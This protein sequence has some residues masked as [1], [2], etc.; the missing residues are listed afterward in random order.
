MGNIN[1]TQILIKAGANIHTRDNISERTPLLAAANMNQE[2]YEIIKLLLEADA[3]PNDEG[4]YGS[5]LHDVVSESCC[6][7]STL[8]LLSYGADVNKRGKKMAYLNKTPLEVANRDE[9]IEIL[10]RD[11][12]KNSLR[13]RASI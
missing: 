3:N 9:I 6:I 1:Q 5:V 4:E 10:M 11:S 7:R 12:K 13:R 8:I 2:R